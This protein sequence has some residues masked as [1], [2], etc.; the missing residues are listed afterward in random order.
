M[1][2]NVIPYGAGYF[3]IGDM[4]RAGLWMT[5]WASLCVTISIAVMGPFVN[6]HVFE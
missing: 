6:L 3:S 4:V 1:P 2:T 5:I